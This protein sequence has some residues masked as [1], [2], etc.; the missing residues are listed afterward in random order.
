MKSS[1]EKFWKIPYQLLLVILIILC[2]A[3]VYQLRDNNQHMVELRNKVYQA[4]ENGQGVEASLNNLRTYVYSHMNTN[5]SSG[6]NS[7]KPPI[8]LAHTY[9]RLVDEVN[10][11]AQAANSK[12][13]TDAQN[14]CQGLNP[15]DFSGKNRVPCVTAYVTSH[16]VNI[17]AVPAGLYE[18]DFVSPIWSPDLAGWLAVLS[19]L[20]GIATLVNYLHRKLW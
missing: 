11:K 1:I 14:Y 20:M 18:F 17:P 13:Y 7:I 3:S 5:L 9:Q 10:A 19:G 2:G 6:G 16:G 8:Q 4:D 12:I 15:T